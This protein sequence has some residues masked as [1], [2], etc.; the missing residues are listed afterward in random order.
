[1]V[2][3]KDVIK[4]SNVTFALARIIFTVETALWIALK[5]LAQTV[6]APV[7]EVL[8]TKTHK[9]KPPSLRI[10]SEGG[11]YSLKYSPD[12]ALINACYV[13]LLTV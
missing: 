12:F 9:H 10:L 4:I 13:I 8:K 6:I 11:F 7:A 2:L 5:S 1:M 3:W